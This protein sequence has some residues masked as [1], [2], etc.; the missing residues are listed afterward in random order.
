MV[1]NG[2]FSSTSEVVR[3]GLRLLDERQ[4]ERE[5]KIK[6]L[7]DALQAGEDSGIAEPFTMQELMDEVRAESGV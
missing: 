4:K 7:Q 3:A 1:K 2:G 6:A 5:V